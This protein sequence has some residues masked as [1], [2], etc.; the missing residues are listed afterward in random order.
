MASHDFAGSGESPL[1]SRQNIVCRLPGYPLALEGG[2]DRMPTL[3]SASMAP[4]LSRALPLPKTV[5]FPGDD[6]T[7]G[8]GF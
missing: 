3:S 6:A 7:R 2:I 5:P 8:P 4:A 1:F